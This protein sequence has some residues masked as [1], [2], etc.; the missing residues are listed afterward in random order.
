MDCTEQKATCSEF[1]VQGFPT[2]K[3]FGTNKERP[4]S[5]EGGRDLASLTSYATERWQKNQPPPEVRELIDQETWE[6]HCLGHD[7]NEALDLK[8][9]KPKQLCLVAF[10]PHILDS[11]SKG[12]N[13]AIDMLKELSLRYK[14]RP[15]SWF[16]AEGGSQPKLEANMDIG[17]FGFPAF[18]ALSPSKGK[19]ATLKGAFEADALKEFMDSVRSGG[20]QTYNIN[21][22]LSAIEQR[23]PWNGEDAAAEAEEEFS[24]EDLG[25]GG[26][27]DGEL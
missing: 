23:D 10:L 6:E 26:G 3:F 27:S 7:A 1:G 5:Y 19:Y 4:E 11:K 22:E 16:W 2:I 20:S 21:G 24:L 15:F 18:V 13:A 25:I 17:G 14:D 12:R 9:V 8:G